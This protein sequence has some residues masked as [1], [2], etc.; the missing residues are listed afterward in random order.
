M[1]VD[2][3][4]EKQLLIVVMGECR[5]GVMDDFISH[6]YNMEMKELITVVLVTSM[7]AINMQLTYSL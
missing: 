1:E 3:V 6:H 4:M 5:C 2:F 7:I